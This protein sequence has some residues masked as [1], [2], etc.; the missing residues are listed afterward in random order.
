MDA[1]AERA[2]TAA[3]QEGRFADM[4][5]TEFSLPHFESALERLGYT[6]VP[7]AEYERLKARPQMRTVERRPPLTL[8]ATDA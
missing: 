8:E 6:I 1:N 5:R 2:F 7:I 4:A 3:F